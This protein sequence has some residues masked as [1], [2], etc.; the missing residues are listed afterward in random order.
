[1]E[2]GS[3]VGAKSAVLIQDRVG[4][5]V[6]KLEAKSAVLMACMMMMHDGGLLLHGEL[7]SIF[8]LGRTRAV[9]CDL[10]I[11]S[12]RFAARRLLPPGAGL[13]GLRT[14]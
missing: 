6:W 14:Y 3:E 11:R 12:Q 4:Q 9:L 13:L 5:L 10:Y 8:V 7:M 2:A 1:M